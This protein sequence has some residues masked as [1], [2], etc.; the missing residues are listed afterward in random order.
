MA[1]QFDLRLLHSFCGAT[2]APLCLRMQAAFPTAEQLLGTVYSLS[3]WLLL[4][5]RL[6]A[7]SPSGRSRQLNG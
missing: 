7:F 3:P 5:G 1:S 6:S 2:A 4:G